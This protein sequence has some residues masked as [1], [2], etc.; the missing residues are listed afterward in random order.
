MKQAICIVPLF[1]FTLCAKAQWKYP[2][3]K[4]SDTTTNY[5]G[6][7]ITDQYRWLEKLTDPQVQDWFKQQ[8]NLSAPI[9]S[10][11]KG[12]D[13][14]FRSFVALNKLKGDQYSNMTMK[15]GTWFY[16][17]IKPG[18]KVA[19]LYFRTGLHAKEQLLLDPIAILKGHT[20]SIG[21]IIPSP[22]GR[23]LIVGLTEGGAEIATIKIINV[24]TRKFYKDKLPP[25]IYGASDWLNNNAIIYTAQTS[26]DKYA[27]AFH[28]NTK[29]MLHTLGTGSKT[30]RELF[31]RAKYSNLSILPED[32]CAISLDDE[33]KYLVAYGF[34]ADNALKAFYAPVATASRAVIP[35]KILL[36]KEDKV[37]NIV[38]HGNDLYLLTFKNAQRYQV[39]KTTMS[40]PDI[41]HAGVVVKE[42]EKKIDGIYLMKDQLLLTLRDGIN[43]NLAAYNFHDGKLKPLAA[44][45]QGDISV[46]HST[47]ENN[48]AI[49]NASSWVKPRMVYELDAVN[50]TYRPS[51]FNTTIHYPGIAG[52]RVEEVQVP[53]AD[54]VMVPLSIFYD[55]SVKLD[56]NSSCIL[57]GYGCYGISYTP[58]FNE[59]NLALLQRGVVLA[60]AHVRGGGEKG[61][62]WHLG[63][64]K[65]TKPNTWKDFI[66]CAEYL[67]NHGYTRKERLA[68]TGTSAGGILI[69]RAITDRPDLFAAAVCNVGDANALRS[70]YGTDGPANSKEYGTDKDSVECM[71]L[72]AMDGLSHVKKGVSYPALLCA[73]GIN[74]PR[75]APWQPGKFAAAV[76]NASSSGKP[77]LLRVDYDNGHFTEDHIVT[78]N[79]FADQYAFMLWQTGRPDF[80][81]K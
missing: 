76:Q 41:A 66:A 7:S 45:L 25:T 27:L 70:E 52:L 68:G 21:D 79:N 49:I 3:T 10:Q 65:T 28:L 39:I 56:G 44:R 43:S 77:V 14:L 15:N 37:T 60:V 71:A 20:Y 31:S 24:A 22:D 12:R 72:I 55:S 30:D 36:K 59:M 5:F 16:K 13:S 57:N 69:S 1:L 73:T 8:S 46:S 40:N 75:V 19:S 42:S 47:K 6:K 48:I 29:A 11:I 54:G 26:F 63:G 34:T 35:W 58:G 80:Q 62:D 9:L 78:F 38:T 17:K 18:E 67:C 32:I 23:K 4:T 33:R 64:F 61:E 2:A 81:G 50:D 53:S 74:D 51:V